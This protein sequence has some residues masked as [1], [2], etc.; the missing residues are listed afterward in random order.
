MSKLP[1]M[2]RPHDL[3]IYLPA[4]SMS[5]D[6]R[7]ST[8]GGGA[9]NQ[10]LML[11]RGLAERGVKVCVAA[12]DESGTLPD[13]IDGV[14]VARRV[15]YQARLGARGQLREAAEIYR[16]IDAADAN[17]V[18]ARSAVPA[19]AL[20]AWSARLQRRRFLYSS[21]NI[22]DFDIARVESNP[23]NR[24]LVRH[25]IRLAEQI[26]VQTEE[27]QAL[28]EQSFR[29]APTLIRSIVQAAPLRDAEPEAFVWAGRICSYKRPLAFVELARA[30]P[31]ARF[32]MV[33][34]PE[35][36]EESRKLLEEVRRAADRVPNLELLA[37][38]TRPA[39]AALIG[40]AVAT[41]N[42][43][44]LEGVSNVL[45]EGWAQG[46]PGIALSYDPDGLIERQGLGGFAAGSPARL[47][48]IVRALWERRHHQNDLA[49]RCQRYVREHHAPDSVYAQW[50]DALALGQ[51]V[52]GGQPIPI[53][54]F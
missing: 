2:N 5:I 7:S 30:V 52:E 45:L 44:D 37:P 41:V 25:G 49:E 51:S 42:T 32:R 13:S 8:P 36:V 31:D 15:L 46:V 24:R 47:A 1:T 20:V 18:L 34:V 10:M 35:G 53:G 4:I 11:A 17:V 19:V 9:E 6:P 54:A 12:F 50:L 23:R 3:M 14:D 27:Q 21:A 16:C 33:C 29:R 26:V 38:L 40:R 48:M 28:C 43:A 39:L 22:F